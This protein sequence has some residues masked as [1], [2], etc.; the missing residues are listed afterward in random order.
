MAESW[1]L[2]LKRVAEKHHIIVC[3]AG[4][5]LDPLWVLSDINIIPEY[6]KTFF[7]IRLL[8]AGASLTGLF[9]KRH[10]STEL[11]AFIP[12][13]GISLQNAYMYS[14]MNVEQL[15]QH[16]FAYIALFIGAGML[17]FWKPVYT[18]IV[19]LVSLIGNL[20]FFMLYSSLSTGEVLI[21]GGLL[22][23]T[24]AIFSIL[25]I[26]TRYQLTKKE[27]VSRFALAASN[28][29]LELQKSII[30]EKNKD[31]TDSISYAKNIQ[32]AI[33]PNDT[34]ITKALK[35]H[36]I[37]YKPKDIVSGDF[38]WFAQKRDKIFIAACDC[39]GHGVPGAFVSMIGNNLLNQ[40]VLEENQSDPGKILT[41]LNDGMKA[42]FTRDAEQKAQDGMDMSLLRFDLD[43]SSLELKTVKFAG[44]N[45]PLYLVRKG[46]ASTKIGKQ[47]ECKP[48]G[49][50]LGEWKGDKTPIGGESVLG[51]Q[52]N[53][54]T[55][56]LEKGDCL[57]IFSDGYHDQFGGEKGKKFMSKRF[58]DLLLNIQ[59]K[60]MDEQKEILAQTMK[61]W[62]GSREQIDDQ[63]V[64][65]IRI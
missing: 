6:W 3:W 44:A 65:G 35:D 24:V 31:I 28:Q 14:V 55:I 57:Y 60:A 47:N 25:L 18:I 12:V 39:T 50:D 7:I 17:V 61:D 9:L 45:N 58:K 42:V 22:T 1:Q 41:L 5:I 48:F 34:E 27:I 38:Y 52:F 21:N 32:Q 63:L 16:T 54:R 4:G 15:Q 56:D 40:I 8:V 62:I 19:V 64:I 2:E 13:M 51:Y 20:F 30:E 29:E 46:I 37:F 43:E 10:I 53:N 36:F 59:L 11:L 23:A 33:L 26:Q 49:E